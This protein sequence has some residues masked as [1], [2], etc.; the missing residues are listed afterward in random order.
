MPSR[1]VKGPAVDSPEAA[2]VDLPYPHY[3]CP[4]CGTE[5]PLTEARITVTC[6]EHGA[7][8]RKVDAAIRDAQPSDRAAVEEI[9]DRVWGETDID[10]FGRTFDVLAADNI[11]AE[12]DGEFAGL[13]SLAIDRGDLAIVM[14]SV[15]PDYQGSGI[16]SSLLEAAVTRAQERRLPLVK[17]ATTNDDIPALYFYQRH[18]FAIYEIAAGTM[19]D[20]HGAVLTGFARIPVRD[21]IRLRR[22]APAR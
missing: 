11:V 17:A 5:L 3:E 9:C 18:G 20:H 7:P 19:V 15:Y 2:E 1:R 13:V 16:G 10:A 12:V 14:L 22:P 4:A 21:E 8:G 6:A